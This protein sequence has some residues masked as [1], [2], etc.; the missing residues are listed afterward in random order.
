MVCCMLVNE[1]GYTVSGDDCSVD[2]PGFAVIQC[3]VKKVFNGMNLKLIFI[4]SN[5]VSRD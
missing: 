1:P 5:A 3:V 2:E 4:Y